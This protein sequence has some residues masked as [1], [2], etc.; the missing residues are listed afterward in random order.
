VAL[1]AGNQVNRSIVI[2]S[3]SAQ[4]LDALATIATELGQPD[5]AAQLQAQA[6]KMRDAMLAR[7]V[8]HDTNLFLDGVFAT[9]SSP[10]YNSSFIPSHS[11]ISSQYFAVGFGVLDQAPAATQA[12]LGT[13]IMALV[14]NKTLDQEGEPACSCMGGHWLLEALYTLARSPTPELSAGA[15]G[16]VSADA[17]A[18]ALAFLTHPGTWLGMIAAGA[19]ATMEVWTPVTLTEG[20][21]PPPPKRPPCLS[22]NASSLTVRVLRCVRSCAR[23]SP[24]R[25]QR[26]KPNLSWSHPWCSAPANIIPRR[27]MGVQPLGV[28]Y[29][30]FE[31]ILQPGALAWATLTL[32]TVKGKIELRFNSTLNAFAASLTVPPGSTAR[33]CLPP[34]VIAAESAGTDSDKLRVDGAVVGGVV[35]GRML[36]A[37]ANLTAGAHNIS[38]YR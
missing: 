26:D 30:H 7:M 16:G 8:D 1:C 23:S 38:R 18:S 9:P 5:D 22:P 4:T 3:Y 33:V 11:A 25:A 20:L 37:P 13:A 6:S 12:K 24:A 28:G 31:V 32:P 27:L 15:G 10:S 21:I 35:L 34:P 19:T 17:A 29:S 14:H 36:C 2:N